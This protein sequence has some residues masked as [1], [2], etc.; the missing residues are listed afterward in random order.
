MIIQK[1]LPNIY[2][3][4]ASENSEN[5]L[6]RYQVIS[7][8]ESVQ[9]L[10]PEC[11]YHLENDMLCFNMDDD[12]RFE[13][14]IQGETDSAQWDEY[15][16][17]F[18]QS[19]SKLQLNYKIKGRPDTVR[20]MNTEKIAP[21]SRKSH[22]GFMIP[23]RS[24]E[25]FYGLGEAA[26][27]SL[28]LRGGEYQ[29][30][31]TYQFDEIPI[32]FVM[33]TAGWGIL[34]N[35]SGR[36]YVDIGKRHQDQ[37]VVMGD[38]DDLDIFVFRGNSLQ[39]LLRCYTQV[40]GPMM[41]LPKWA[42]GLTYIPSIVANQH[43]VLTDART[44]RQ[45]HIPCDHISIE[46]QWMS[47]FYDYSLEK[48][49]NLEW[50]H[51][52]DFINEDGRPEFGEHGRNGRYSFI[53]ALRRHGFHV[54]LWLCN[55]YDYTDEAERIAQ[56]KEKGQLAPWY[57]HLKKFVNQG[58]DGFKLDPADT[59]DTNC[60][61]MVCANGYSEVEMHNLSQVLL[62]K[63]VY[64]GMA[65]QL[66]QRPMLHYCGGYTGVHRWTAASTG[67]NGG[68]KGAMIW[69]L[70]LGLSGHNNT[71]VDMDIHFKESM[72]FAMFAPWAHLNAWL[73]CS[74]PWW[75]TPEM[76]ECFKDYVHL[77]YRLLPYIYST[78]LEAR[79]TAM[80]ILRPMPLAFPNDGK[81]KNLV[82]QYMFGPDLM[83]QSYSDKVVFPDGNWVDLWT[84]KEYA[85]GTSID[86]MPPENRGGGLFV[87]KGA[88]IPTWEDRDYVDQKSDETIILEIWPDGNSSYIL[89][90]DD[91]VSLDYLTQQSCQTQIVCEE[92]ENH[93]RISIGQRIGEY[94]NK[95]A[96]RKW[97]VHVHTHKSVEAVCPEED[98]VMVEAITK[99]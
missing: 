7:V 38:E 57:E 96:C 58:V 88:I 16:K 14:H 82:E 53:D 54:S 13:M 89:R 15:A 40:T 12:F 87:R 76:Y 27:N 3:I 37:M 72:H 26:Q 24:D 18:E 92:T 30:W 9:T 49:W 55:Q 1:I 60:P 22:F 8:P 93:V 75:E 86:Y 81:V 39:E 47:R 21:K 29:N 25:D 31:A 64:E 66:N 85:G 67:D 83:I 19:F 52:P 36:H 56:G 59:L 50:F 35:A 94:T 69:L 78:A 80:P 84:G 33:S 74:Q 48:Q 11:D 98:E 41:L 73:G 77:R 43:E 90:E 65:N 91:G 34:I 62:P 23:I 32:P 97:I 2:R 28:N 45:E 61:D 51:M 5:L 17:G 20:E 46:P 44:F 71:T 4:R 99:L 6:E 68:L 79:E 10:C 63:Q 95:P 42:Y 70:S